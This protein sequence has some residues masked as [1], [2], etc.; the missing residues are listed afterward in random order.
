MER[1][2]LLS[3]TRRHETSRKRQA[4][5]TATPTGDPVAQGGYNS[6]GDRTGCGCLREFSVPLGLSV[7]QT[8]AAGA[9]VAPDAWS[10]AGSLSRTEEASGGSAPERAPGRW[11]SNRSLDLT[12]C[13][14]DDPQAVRGALPSLSFLAL[15]FLEAP[16]QFGM[17]LSETRT[18]SPATGHRGHRPV[19]ASTLAPC[20]KKTPRDVVPTSSSLMN[21]VSCSSPTWRASGLRKTA[22]RSRATTISKIGCRQS[23]PWP[24][25]PSGDGW[26][27]ILLS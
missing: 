26:R 11:L 3:Y 14:P 10:S 24:Y 16:D 15:S 23:V 27:S 21:R 25:C 13:R 6:V 5:G 9:A 7:P 1:Q 20:N 22:R 2:K 18:P 8:R 12:A 19:E 4:T 17:E